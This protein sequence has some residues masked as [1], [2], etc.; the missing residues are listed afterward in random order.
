MA[1]IKKKGWRELTDYRPSSNTQQGHRAKP[2][3][4]SQE[5][6]LCANCKYRCQILEDY[7]SSK[8]RKMHAIS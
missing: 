2:G 8:V 6:K 4:S 7:V 3:I 5:L 1:K